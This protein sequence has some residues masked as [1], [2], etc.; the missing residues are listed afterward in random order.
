MP[1]Q[2]NIA[3]LSEVK[4]GSESADANPAVIFLHIP[5][6]AGTSFN[7]ALTWQ[8]RGKNTY[9]IHFQ[10]VHSEDFKSLPSSTKDSF[11]LIRGHTHFG[12]HEHVNRRCTYITV[13]REPRARIL[14]YYLNAQSEA[15]RHTS[16]KHWWY[17]AVRSKSLKELIQSGEDMELENGQVRRISGAGFRKTACTEA[18]LNQAIE[19]IENC[20]GAVGLTERF[21]ETLLLVS[22]QLQWKRCLLYRKSKISK[23]RTQISDLDADTIRTIDAT[24][25]LDAKLYTYIKSRFNQQTARQGTLFATRAAYWKTVNRLL[26]PLYA[27]AR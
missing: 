13:V 23:S 9:Q 18:D 7:S 21:D 20:F 1:Q 14:S 19:N 2:S 10:D 22:R 26:V 16:S 3:E 17:E 6:T 25:E 12:L 5:K 27:F 8:Y 15:A 24:N 11:A 4:S